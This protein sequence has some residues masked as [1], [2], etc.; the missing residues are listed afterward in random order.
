MVQRSLCAGRRF[1]KSESG[2]KNRPA[3]FEMTGKKDAARSVVA[4]AVLDRVLRK[5]DYHGLFD[6]FAGEG[7]AFF[8]ACG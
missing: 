2:R 6:L 7:V 8:A 3:P 4:G 1:R 5:R